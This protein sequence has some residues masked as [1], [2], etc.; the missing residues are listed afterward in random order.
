[1]KIL[2]CGGRDFSNKEK[3]FSTLY[4][5]LEEYRA[6]LQIIS[7]MAKG[8]DLIGWLFAHI[9]DLICL[10]FPADWKTHGKA[11]ILEELSKIE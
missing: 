8:A 4:P 10:E 1:M 6:D 7:G 9:Y 11:E 5:Y 2:V 3:V